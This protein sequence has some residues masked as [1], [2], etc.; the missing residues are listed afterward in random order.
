MALN[1]GIIY[2]PGENV[3]A[4][5]GMGDLGITIV[6]KGEKGMEII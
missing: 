5:G 3:P 2:P 4:E 1:R 6:D